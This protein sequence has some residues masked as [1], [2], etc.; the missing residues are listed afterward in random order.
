MPL[1]FTLP[2]VMF[3]NGGKIAS[4]VICIV[5]PVKGSPSKALVL[6]HIGPG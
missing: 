4:T 2:E 1:A 3:I 5:S 6:P